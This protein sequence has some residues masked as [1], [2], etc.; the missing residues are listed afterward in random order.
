[1]KRSLI[2]VFALVIPAM[3]FAQGRMGG[4]NGLLKGFGLDDTQISQ[5]T[6]IE[7][8]TRATVRADFTHIRL[9]RAQIAEALLPATPDVQ[10]INALIDKKGEFRTDIEKNLVSARIQLVKI[11][12]DENYATFARFAM[13][14]IRSRFGQMRPM[15][16]FGHPQSMETAPKP[17]EG[18]GDQ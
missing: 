17:D 18:G 16:G 13:D 5:V 3:A 1:M 8:S 15:E 6:A 11:M 4:E 14:R 12:G 2:A 9:I 7:K 10:A